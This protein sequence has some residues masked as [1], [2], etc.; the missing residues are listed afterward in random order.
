[1]VFLEPD[2]GPKP[3]GF[4]PIWPKICRF[5]DR[6]GQ[7]LG[8]LWFRESSFGSGPGKAWLEGP[9]KILPDF[10]QNPGFSGF[11]WQNLDFQDFDQILARSDQFG[12][13]P[14]QNLRFWP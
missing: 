3:D 5:W 13:D 10:G 2:S 4:R 8:I 7:G 9:T 11:F 12:S 1:M 6:F 14:G